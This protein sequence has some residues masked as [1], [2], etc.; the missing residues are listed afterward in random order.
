MS[1]PPR[2][3]ERQAPEVAPRR[4][5]VCFVTATL[6]RGGA[7]GQLVHLAVRLDRT[8]F[9]PVVCCLTHDGPHREALEAAGVP[10]T[11]LGVGRLQGLRAPVALAR[12]LV[13]LVLAV[14]SLR[15]D[16]VHGF[17]YSAY[18]LGA[19]AARVN[20]VPVVIA[21]RRSLGFFKASKPFWL[22]VERWANHR[23]DLLIANSEAVRQDV[24]RQEGQPP[25]KV[26]VIYNG[27]EV[28]EVSTERKVALRGA[29][30]LGDRHPIVAVVANF[31]PY[32]G[33]DVLFDALPE[34]AAAFPQMAVLLA[35]DG[36]ERTRL[37]RRARAGG[38]SGVVR[39]LGV[40]ADVATLLALAD[41]VVHPST[42]EGFSNA[43]L[44]AMAAGKPVVAAAVG[45]NLE[46]VLD[47]RTGLLVPAR[48]ARA[49]AAATLRLLRSPAEARAMGEAGRVRACQQFTIERMVH[50][51]E[52]I[53]ERLL[54]TAAG[55]GTRTCAA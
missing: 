50:D 38:L 10:V 24:V 47:G 22:F 13:R 17:L 6:D 33:H 52:R 11:A 14:R 44:E 7:E 36:S 39:F 45:G 18:V 31:M 32:K 37:E 26:S 55:R 4:V 12:R 16:V 48:D 41:V 9:D 21:S 23:T 20:R 8:R 27:V 35:G 34:L 49:L 42:E 2:S 46:A 30:D 1:V 29:L 25:S 40:R 3:G 19:I 51:Y 54:A 53:Y 15:P 43:V 5:R 28:S